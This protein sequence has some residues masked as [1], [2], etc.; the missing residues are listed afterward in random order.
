MKIFDPYEN[1]VTETELNVSYSDLTT[2][3]P[4]VTQTDY[5][6]FVHDFSNT[7]HLK[8][9]K[10][11]WDASKQT[12]LLDSINVGQHI[13]SGDGRYDNI[14]DD[15]GTV[16]VGWDWFYSETNGSS[17]NPKLVKGYIDDPTITTLY[18]STARIDR[19]NETNIRAI[20]DLKPMLIDGQDVYFKYKDIT[21]STYYANPSAPEG[22]EWH[23]E[24][25]YLKKNNDWSID[26]YSV[27]SEI[28]TNSDK[29]L[30]FRHIK[31]LDSQYLII[32]A[33]DRH[34]LKVSKSS[35][36]IVVN[37][38][39]DLAG[40]LSF[41]NMGDGGEKLFDCLEVNHDDNRFYLS[42]NKT[43]YSIDSDVSAYT[44]FDVSTYP[45]LQS[46]SFSINDIKYTDNK[47]FFT[48]GD[49]S[50]GETITETHGWP[51]IRYIDFNITGVSNSEKIKVHNVHD[52]I[53][54]G[55][56]NCTFVDWFVNENN[57]IIL[58]DDEYGVRRM[59]SEFIGENK[60]IAL[61]DAIGGEQ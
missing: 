22:Y 7:D 45:S 36:T 48:V 37:T 15:S 32:L 30:G 27:E 41:S 20:R 33:E 60:G 11:V 19:G 53:Y 49:E 9:T 21:G 57:V 14:W 12:I 50:T 38:R 17:F 3:D 61:T 4:T 18:S 51:I 6:F 56:G 34:L 2:Y 31:S 40:S 13:D 44:A 39:I 43:I 35:G 26:A 54:Y 28:P 1:A 47:L 24:T 42:F 16:R 29:G 46:Q 52:P 25:W 8:Y 55:Y 23:G 59:H 5:G 10:Y 58:F